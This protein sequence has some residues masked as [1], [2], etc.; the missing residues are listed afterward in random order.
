MNVHTLDRVLVAAMASMGSAG[1]EEFQ[2]QLLKHAQ[3]SVGASGEQK[4][5]FYDVVMGFIHAIDWNERWI[6]SILL[7]HGLM[8][9]TALVYRG[10]SNVQLSIFLVALGVVWCAQPLNSLGAE[11]WEDFA[12]QP[13]F[14]KYGAFFSAVVSCPLVLVMLVVLVNCIVIAVSEMVDLKRRQLKQQA[15]KQIAGQP[16]LS[17]SSGKAD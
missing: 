8:L 10:S 17:K 13:Y 12:T 11:Y 4:E 5:G 6:Q 7:F 15:R 9:L 14:D 16:A 1:M 3:A 2:R